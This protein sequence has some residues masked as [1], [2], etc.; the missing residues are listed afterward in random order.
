MSS[1]TEPVTRASYVRALRPLLSP[2]AFLR[3]P[4]RLARIP[5]LVAVVAFAIVARRRRLGAVA[6]AAGRLASSIGL[7]FAGLAFVGHEPMHGG[8]GRRPPPADGARL[9]HVPAVHAVTA[10]VDRLAQRRA[11]RAH[12]RRRRSRRLPDA[13]ALQRAAQHALL[14]RYVL[15]RRPALA[16]R[17]QP[18]AR[19]HRPERRPADQRPWQRLHH[20]ARATMGARRD[21]ARPRVVGGGRGPR[22]A[23]GVRVRVR[24]AA[25]RRQRLRD[26]V[27]PDEPQ[28]EP[29]RRDQRS[30][31]ERAHGD[32]VAHRRAGS[33]SALA[34]TSSITC[35]RR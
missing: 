18:R 35:S 20:G 25:A 27:H 6:A 34:T 7:S 15:A 29:A 3:A 23:A 30:A 19:V 16:R 1:S 4:S 5:V 31:R 26:G 9:A 10:P 2:A 32:D 14:G 22:R 13:R 17:A 8:D 24:A 28:L 21:R 33:P 11:P 12:E